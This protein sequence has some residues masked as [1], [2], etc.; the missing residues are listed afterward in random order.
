MPGYPFASS[1][2]SVKGVKT[3]LSVV[4]SCHSIRSIKI[5]LLLIYV[6]LQSSSKVSVIGLSMNGVLSESSSWPEKVYVL[7]PSA[8][9]ECRAIKSLFDV[10]NK[11]Y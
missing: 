3:L 4:L 11:A 6:V 5:S 8:I 9:R 7:D 1:V 2:V 10:V